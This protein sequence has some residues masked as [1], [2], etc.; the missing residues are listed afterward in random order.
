MYFLLIIGKGPN[1]IRS[2]RSYMFFI[3][4]VLKTFAT[5]T[6]RKTSVLESLFNK[7]AGLLL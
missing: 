1:D 2:S 5:F 6:H 7:V 3:I 4:G